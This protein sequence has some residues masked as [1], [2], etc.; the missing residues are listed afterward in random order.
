[1]YKKYV[2]W[3]NFLPDGEFVALLDIQAKDRSEA[4]SS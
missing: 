1:M 3:D 2:I 4:I